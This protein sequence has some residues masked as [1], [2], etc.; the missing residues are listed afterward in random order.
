MKAVSNGFSKRSDDR[1]KEAIG[2]ING[3]MIRIRHPSMRYDTLLNTVGFF[4]S[5]GF[6]APN[7]QCIAGHQK[8]VIWASHSYEDA[9]HDSH[10]FKDTDLYKIL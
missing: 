4:S 7:V 6:F 2:V 5:K 10:R 3:W 9:S 8:K 1:L